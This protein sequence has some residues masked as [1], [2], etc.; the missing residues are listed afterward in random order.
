MGRRLTSRW[1]VIFCSFFHF[2]HKS[3]NHSHACLQWCN[4][5]R[6]SLIIPMSDSLSN[7]LWVQRFVVDGWTL[8]SEP[9]TLS[10]GT[11]LRARLR[12]LKG[13]APIHQK[14]NG[15]NTGNGKFRCWC[16]NA[17][18]LL[19]TDLV[20]CLDCK[21]RNR[22]SLHAIAKH[23]SCVSG[24]ETKISPRTMR[25]AQ[26]RALARRMRLQDAELGPPGVTALQSRCKQ[27]WWCSGWQK[28]VAQIREV[29]RK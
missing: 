13:D 25:I 22:A 11:I 26:L 2:D 8:L 14:Q 16:C 10:D 12:F 15:V 20:G 3:F 5:P 27:R 29:F 23:L 21:P 7:L 18:V 28:V 1:Q 9:I 19:Y 24:C 6:M 17:P 4:E